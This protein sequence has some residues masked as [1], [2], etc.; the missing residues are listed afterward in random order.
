MVA[1]SE[2]I[3]VE[4]ATIAIQGAVDMRQTTRRHKEVVSSGSRL[5]VK[6]VFFLRTRIPVEVIGIRVL[7]IV[8]AEDGSFGFLRHV[9]HSQADQRFQSTK[10]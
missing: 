6:E 2:R 5:H 4:K 3:C 7:F 8:D 10:D 1:V 9:S